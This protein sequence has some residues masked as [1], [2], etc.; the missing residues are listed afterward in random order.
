MCSEI[1]IAKPLFLF[2]RAAINNGML[3]NID[4][5]DNTTTVP[6]VPKLE[7]PGATA[8]MPTIPA[9]RNIHAAVL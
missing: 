3:V 2:L 1:G 7:L 9:P 4:K 6:V 8:A 5:P